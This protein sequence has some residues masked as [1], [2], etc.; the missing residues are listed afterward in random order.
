MLRIQVIAHR[1]AHENH[2]ENSIAAY[3]AAIHLGCDFI[4]VDLRT[5]EEGRLVI[6]HDAIRPGDKLPLLDDVLALAKGRIRIYLD[7]KQAQP[8]AI[9]A[10]VE[11]RGMSGSILTYGAFQVLR[12]LV[13][14]RPGWPCMPE[15]VNAETL[16]RSLADLKPPAIAFSDWDFKPE[17]VAMAREAGCEVFLDRQGKTDYPQYWAAAIEAGATGIQTDRPGAL[18][19]WL[20]EQGMRG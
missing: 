15:A 12:D 11:Q 5:T 8:A 1:G 3:E 16:R 7:V 20:R 17:L 14:L 13:A 19:A 6:K 18:L 4:E 9:I 2:P 10:A